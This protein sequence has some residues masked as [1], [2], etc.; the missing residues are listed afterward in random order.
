MHFLSNLNHDKKLVSEIDCSCRYIIFFNQLMYLFG[1][2]LNVVHNMLTFIAYKKSEL[3]NKPPYVTYGKEQYEMI[4]FK[5]KKTKAY[6][7]MLSDVG[8]LKSF[9]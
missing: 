1:S 6:I 9:A 3:K 4:C 8:L 7:Y 2:A 5:K